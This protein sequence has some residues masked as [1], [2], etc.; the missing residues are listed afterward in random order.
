MISS[1]QFDKHLR[2]LE[3][4]SRAVFVCQRR[5]QCWEN[6]T[7]RRQDYL[8]KESN[9]KSCRCNQNSTLVC[10]TVTLRSVLV[11]HLQCSPLFDCG[12]FKVAVKRSCTLL[13]QFYGTKRK[14]G[15]GG[16]LQDASKSTTCK[17]GRVRVLPGPDPVRGENPLVEGALKKSN[18]TKQNYLKKTNRAQKPN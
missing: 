7:A 12:G 8:N 4:R 14:V 2:A 17:R 1:V 13:L 3:A 9:R 10:L 5:C 6:Y 15:A 16:R 11:E 18:K